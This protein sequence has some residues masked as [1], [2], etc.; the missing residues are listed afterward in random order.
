MLKTNK[1]VS[2]LKKTGL[3][4]KNKS[5]NQKQVNILNHLKR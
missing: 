5:Q 4:F 1:I 2:E 3:Q